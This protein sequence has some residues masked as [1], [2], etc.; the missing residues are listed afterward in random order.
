MVRVQL[1]QLSSSIKLNKHYNL[2]YFIDDSP[3]LQNRFMGL[4][5]LALIY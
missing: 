4:R 5:S 1:V 2:K 3:S